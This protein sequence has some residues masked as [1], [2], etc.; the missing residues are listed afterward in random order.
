M[1]QEGPFP[2]RQSPLGRAFCLPARSQDSGQKANEMAK[3]SSERDVGNCPGF[4]GSMEQR[5][6]CAMS[7]IAF[8]LVALVAA[9]AGTGM[10]TVA[11]GASVV[12]QTQRRKHV[13]RREEDVQALPI[14]RSPSAVQAN[15]NDISRSSIPVMSTGSTFFARWASVSAATG[16]R[17]DVSQ[18]ESFNSYVDG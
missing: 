10:P 15:P 4:Y 8:S 17:L 13:S 11:S 14:Y 1:P 7:S 5:M 16:Y 18:Q 6:I 3:T 9:S 2:R 12:Y